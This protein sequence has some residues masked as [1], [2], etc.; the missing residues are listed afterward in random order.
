MASVQMLAALMTPDPTH[1][2]HSL[3]PLEHLTG[4]G[5]R[6]VNGRTSQE[7]FHIICQGKGLDGKGWISCKKEVNNKEGKEEPSKRGTIGSEKR[8][9]SGVIMATSIWTEAIP[10]NY[11]T[12][13]E[14][15][16]SLKFT[17]KHFW[18]YLEPILKLFWINV[19]LLWDDHFCMIFGP[20]L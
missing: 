12:G 19:I 15:G 9:R 4:C 10:Y 7:S 13:V 16:H 17:F 11:C 1:S 6:R 2:A 14:R 8:V 20:S 3:R 5:E 18:N